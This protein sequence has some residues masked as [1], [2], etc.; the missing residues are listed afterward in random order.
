MRN[1]EFSV[2]S[3]FHLTQKNI[4]R[5]TDVKVMQESQMAVY[6]NLHHIAMRQRDASLCRRQKGRKK[7][8]ELF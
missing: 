3:D 7:N 1:E 4:D 5:Q 2:T 6:Q 8:V